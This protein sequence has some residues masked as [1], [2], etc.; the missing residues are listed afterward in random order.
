MPIC[1]PVRL[2]AC[3]PS[4]WIAIA[5]SAT[6]SCSPVASSMSI[7]RGGGSSVISAREVDQFVGLA[8]AR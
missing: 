3:S 4:S 8:A 7:S 6:D 5:I 1:P 2:I